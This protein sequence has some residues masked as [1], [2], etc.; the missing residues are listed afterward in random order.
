MKIVLRTLISDKLHSKCDKI[1]R[2]KGRVHQKCT[3]NVMFKQY[4]SVIDTIVENK[5]QKRSNKGI[6]LS[7]KR[8]HN[9]KSTSVNLENN[10][11]VS[12]HDNTSSFEKDKISLSDLGTLQ[13]SSF[14]IR[15]SGG[16]RNRARV[17]YFI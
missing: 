16:Y 7:K 2:R 13:F 14:F 5:I 10:T 15:N 9:N 8:M 12:D 4:H 1:S 17:R 11:V 3:R 6:K